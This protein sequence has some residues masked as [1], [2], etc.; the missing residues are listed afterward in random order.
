MLGAPDF[1][2]ATDAELGD[3]L[4]RPEL[5]R[6]L[7]GGPRFGARRGDL[8]THA[9]E[10]PCE[11]ERDQDGDRER[12]RTGEHGGALELVGGAEQG[13][14]GDDGGDEPVEGNGDARALATDRSDGGEVRAVLGF[15]L[16]ELQTIDAAVLTDRLEQRVE[17]GI[18]EV[19]VTEEL[20]AGGKRELVGGGVGE[21]DAVARED[22]RARL[23]ES[24]PRDI[25][26][27]GADVEVDGEHGEQA[28]VGTVERLGAGDAG[29]EAA[30]ER[31]GLGP[32]AGADA[33]GELIEPAASWIV[34]GGLGAE[35]D[36]LRSFDREAIDV[37][38]LLGDLRFLDLEATLLPEVGAAERSVDEADARVRDARATDDQVGEAEQHVIG[39]ARRVGEDAQTLEEWAG[40]VECE[41]DVGLDRDRLLGELAAGHRLRGA[42]RGIATDEE[43]ADPDGDHEQ[44]DRD[45]HTDR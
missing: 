5:L 28:L 31:V 7:L 20:V 35:L 10:V 8:A 1:P 14:L 30:E 22:H 6:A 29:L 33:L 15:E 3:E 36:E 32:R 17:G 19:L 26:G 18:S 34:V 45:Q 9:D 25:R 13:A 27:Q 2:H 38:A 12:A 41:R 16:E 39:V 42:P 23:V 11:D 43:N 4:V 21:D 44:R 40:L 37:R 24:G